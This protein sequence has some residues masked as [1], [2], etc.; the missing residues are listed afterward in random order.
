MAYLVAVSSFY[1]AAVLETIVDT[2]MEEAL[3]RRVRLA[4]E[5][6]ARADRGQRSKDGRVLDRFIRAADNFEKL[7]T[8]GIKRKFLISTNRR[9]SRFSKNEF[10]SKASPV[11]TPFFKALHFYFLGLP[12]IVHIAERDLSLMRKDM[13]QRFKDHEYLLDAMTMIYEWFFKR[14]VND[15]EARVLGMITPF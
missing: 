2:G 12:N 6:R 15:R 14:E 7:V 3:K 8:Q 4:K 11:A 5:V 10:S 13:Q 9:C 1:Q